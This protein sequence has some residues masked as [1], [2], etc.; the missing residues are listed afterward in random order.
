V[1][2]NCKAANKIHTFVKVE[3]DETKNITL[4]GNYTDNIIQKIDIGDEI[5]ADQV[6]E[7]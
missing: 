1:I 6:I 5:P 4:I 2:K 7:R 3:G